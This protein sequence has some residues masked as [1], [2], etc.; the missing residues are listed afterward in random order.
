MKL[1]PNMT[2]ALVVTLLMSMLR[3][4]PALACATTSEIYM[5]PST[6][7]PDHK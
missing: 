1:K 2:T 5:V 3:M 4:F 6:I 7:S